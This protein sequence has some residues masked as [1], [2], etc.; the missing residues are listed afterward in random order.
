MWCKIHDTRSRTK[1]QSLRL[2][3]LCINSTTTEFLLLGLPSQLNKNSQ[4]STYSQQWHLCSACGF[5][6][7]PWFYLRFSTHFFPIRSLLY[8]VHVFT[9]SVIFDAFGLFLTLAQPI[10]Y[11]GTSLVHSGL[12]YCNSLYYNLP[13]FQLNRLQHNPEFSCSCR[14]CSSQVLQSWPDSEIFALA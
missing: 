10:R 1:S 8:L 6:S 11:I 4:S 2:N 9:I 7:Q 13:K 14:C 3:L 12:D 5:C